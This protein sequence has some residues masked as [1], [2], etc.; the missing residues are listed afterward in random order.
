M[1]NY[2]RNKILRLAW[3]NKKIFMYLKD[4]PV[5]CV[6]AALGYWWPPLDV[7]TV[8]VVGPQVSKFEQVSS[9]GHQMWEV[10]GLMSNWRGVP[11]HVT[12]PM[13]HV[14]LPTYFHLPPEQTNAHENI[15]FTKQ[16]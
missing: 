14:M 10:P 12:Y 11:H 13:V 6:P 1:K 4:I 2:T 15:T 8:G 16:I 7:S 3:G 9:D 5:G